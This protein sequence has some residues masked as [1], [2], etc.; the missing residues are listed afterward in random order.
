MVAIKKRVNEDCTLKIDKGNDDFID[1]FFT[2]DSDE[3]TIER[4]L[5]TDFDE[6]EYLQI[7]PSLKRPALIDEEIELNHKKYILSK[8]DTRGVIEYGNEY[9]VEISGYQEEELVGQPHSIIRHPD[10][11]KVIFKFLWSRIKNRQDIT[12]VVKNLAKDGRYYWVMTEFQIKVDEITDEITGYFAYRRAAPKDVVQKIEP[13]YRKLLDIEKV[14]GV[15]GS[16]KYLTALL[17]SKNIAY[18][19]FI[20]EITGKNSG[21]MK[22]WFIAMKRFFSN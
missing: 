5:K 9:F 4:S 15:N 12:A 18:D 10:M 6:Y 7:K 3:Y 22:L 11:P 14:S 20:N 13:L 17:E 21:M 1:R 16:E 19:D 8:T 2:Q